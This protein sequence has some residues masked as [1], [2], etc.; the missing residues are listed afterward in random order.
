MNSAIAHR[1]LAYS[2]NRWIKLLFTTICLVLIG[3]KLLEDRRGI[4]IQ[5]LSSSIQL[6]QRVPSSSSIV[7]R[8]A[9]KLANSSNDSTSAVSAITSIEIDENKE[10]ANHHVDKGHDFD[11]V[12]WPQLRQRLCPGGVPN[13]S[14]GP[15]LFELGR[16]EMG[17]HGTTT[18]HTFS[19]SSARN[20]NKNQRVAE[21]FYDGSF[22]FTVFID[23]HDSTNTVIYAPIWKCANDQIHLYLHEI[24]NR[25][26]DGHVRRPA[27]PIGN[28]NDFYLEELSDGEMYL[29]L[30]RLLH[31]NTKDRT[32]DGNGG[33][34]NDRGDDQNQTAGA[35]N[36][37]DDDAESSSTSVT[38]SYF[39]FNNTKRDIP[40]SFTVIRDPISHFLSG[41]NEV[42]YRLITG[43]DDA[44]S[45]SKLENLAPYSRMPLV[46][47]DDGSNNDPDNEEKKTKNDASM[48]NNKLYQ[49]LR[50]ERFEQFVHDVLEEHPS[51][52]QFPY[53]KHFASMT[54]ILPMLSKYHLFPK[55]VSS[56]SPSSSLHNSNSN[57]NH[58]FIPTLKNLTEN[59]PAFLAQRCPRVAANYNRQ[60]NEAGQQQQ[61]QQQLPPMK[62]RGKHESSRDP[63]GTYQAAK[64][65]WKRGG[66]VARSL[67]HLHALDYACF[68]GTYG[69]YDE[70]TI[71]PGVEIPLICRDI[72]ASDMFMDEIL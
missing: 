13:I 20:K 7:A 32:F 2:T 33:N 72:F 22:G 63:Y 30:H 38:D 67:C 12:L 40:C 25:K 21:F 29:L 42:E 41:Y 10:G 65:V 68:S 54:R 55:H 44:P 27:L 47:S 14:L 17:I 39:M 62:I 61:Q 23:G 50:E 24:F 35:T 59:F 34:D 52:V 36:D 66:R 3:N 4:A 57:N 31:N 46:E 49:K 8:T 11:K 37:N 56:L 18:P 9:N 69:D 19:N 26:Q 15:T 45:T 70:N 71:Q 5:T 48:K 64:D 1:G 6:R 53:Y 51:F 58:W 43:T 60:K 28:D 16:K